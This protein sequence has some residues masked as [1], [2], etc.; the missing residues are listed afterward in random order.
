[1]EE[2]TGDSSG[3]IGFCEYEYRYV[4]RFKSGVEQAA[5][6]LFFVA[7][8][9]DVR[10]NDKSY[11][12]S[13]GPIQAQTFWVLRGHTQPDFHLRSFTIGAKRQ[14]MNSDLLILQGIVPEL[15][16]ITD[17]EADAPFDKTKEKSHVR[18]DGFHKQTSHYF[19]I[20]TMPT[21]TSLISRFGTASDEIFDTYSMD[22]TSMQNIILGFTVIGR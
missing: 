14:A 4:Q 17:R 21:N 1:M 13:F 11:Y 3:K 20:S 6:K 7:G 16:G 12:W 2:A 8:V 10:I 22:G 19:Q 18:H 15:P 9:Q 5:A